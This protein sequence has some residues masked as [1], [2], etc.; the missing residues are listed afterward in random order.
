MKILIFI[1]ARKGSKG[2]PGKNLI[3]LNGK[4]LIDYTLNT[5]KKLMENSKFDFYPFISSD[6]DKILKFCSEKGFSTDYKRPE[7][8]SG[9]KSILIDAIW[10]ALDWLLKIKNIIPDAVLLLQ[11]TS[12]IRKKEDIENAINS[13]KGKN[14]FSVVSVTKMREHPYEC[15]KINYNNWSY[16][17]E[18][19]HETRGRQDYEDNFFFIDG[20][21]YFA[22]TDFL[23]TN[24][25]FIVR[26][27]TKFHIIK[28]VL[29]IDIDT[30]QDLKIA[31][32]ILV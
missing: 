25:S 7:A 8:I 14:N 24:K 17:S 29:A 10:D 6:D 9:D 15:V 2:I 12:P 18:P 22:S 28:Q 19:V 16:I 13:V 5:V 30:D 11:P 20:N 27:R 23:K 1:P 4:P 31:K 3:D 21:F 32:A 26:N